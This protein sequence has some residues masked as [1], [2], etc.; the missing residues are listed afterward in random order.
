MLQFE[1]NISF[2]TILKQLNHIKLEYDGTSQTL[3]LIKIQHDIQILRWI[4]RNK[5]ELVLS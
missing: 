2:E 3:L 5:Y 1:C 4:V